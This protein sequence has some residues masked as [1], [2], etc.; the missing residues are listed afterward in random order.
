[1]KATK[2]ALSLV[3]SFALIASTAVSTGAFAESTANTEGAQSTQL[4]EHETSTNEGHTT[5]S[6][7]FTWSSSTGIGKTQYTNN[8]TTQSEGRY[9]YYTD[10][11]YLKITLKNKE[12]KAAVPFSSVLNTMTMQTN[13]S[14]TAPTAPIDDMTGN[15]KGRQHEDWMGTQ[16]TYYTNLNRTTDDDAIFYGV[17]QTGKTVD[18][19]NK[20]ANSGTVRTV[21]FTAGESRTVNMALTAKTGGSLD[22]Y[23]L[24]VEAFQQGNPST[25]SAT[26][27]YDFTAHSI[28]AKIG[29]SEYETLAGAIGQAKSGE[30]VTLLKD[31][32]LNDTATAKNEAAITLPAGVTL[33]GNG[34]TITVGT[35]ANESHVLG[36]TEGDVAV[37]NL[38]IDGCNGGTNGKAKH[39]INAWGNVTVTL[40][41]VTLKNSRTAGMVVANGAKVTANDLNTS[42]NAWGAV[43]V[44]DSRSDPASKDTS[45]TLTSGTLAENIQIWTEKPTV[46]F[47]KVPSA[48]TSLTSDSNSPT[49]KGYTY[50]TTDKS[51]LVE[52]KLVESLIDNMPQSPSQEEVNSVVTTVTQLSTNDQKALPATDVEKLE[53]AITTTNTY[54]KAPTQ[55]LTA[56]KDVTENLKLPSAP[57]AT[58]LLLAAG[59][60]GAETDATAVTLKTTQQSSTFSDVK[61]EMNVT[62]NE[63]D[64]SNNL[65]FPVTVTLTLPTSFQQYLNA[66]YTCL[67]KHNDKEL[68]SSD[69]SFD[70][71]NNT[72][73]FTTNSFSPFEVVAMSKT[74]STPSTPTTPTTPVTPVTP[75][76][77]TFVSDTNSALS[78]NGAYT[79]KITSK[80]GK[81]PVFVVGTP[82]SFTVQLVQQSGNNYF[83][84]ITAIGAAGA[85]AGVYVNGTKLLVATVKSGNLTF[86]SD[87][88]SP[89]SV[90]NA[91]TFKITSKN[92]KAPVFVVGTPGIFTTQ[93][94]KHTGNDYF[95]KITVIGAP[96]DQA[97]VYVNGTKLLVATVKTNPSYVLS[98]TH[99]NFK[100]TS[101]KAYVFKLTANAKP[102][103]Q[104]GTPSAFKVSYVNRIGNNYYFR[105]TAVGKAGS[106][107]GFYI[108]N[109]KG[110][111]AVA[112]VA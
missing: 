19:E 51:K 76:H 27:T 54:I 87:T 57:T 34:H 37:K 45:F 106:A 97:G 107:S 50:Y 2:K 48:Y 93:L 8:N 66:S 43:N 69:Y 73:T 64:I 26:L 39:C 33:D 42:G 31:V 55:S 110:P 74:P 40:G 36:C 53:T 96:G 81:A 28:V 77:P 82:G 59:V 90:N 25:A 5:W 17:K 49:L 71:K 32:T 9:N 104:A 94:V 108:Q 21:G 68:P 35:F 63:T 65:Q 11:A 52:S 41:N 111:V 38:T 98:D 88:G 30:T 61:F 70:S 60:T 16:T 47:I 56:D 24:T 44:D 14:D 22:G 84:K 29:S 13:P 18:G 109:Q 95:Y 4:T 102:N 80:D 3:L 15:G 105:V 46:V 91:Y 92:G 103:F 78:V 100:V 62:K 85:Q 6:A 79:F 7:S 72:V 1:M 83:Y 75:D 112:A 12:S 86:V 67:V 23:T 58:G 89:L 20:N 99:G 10:G 101:G